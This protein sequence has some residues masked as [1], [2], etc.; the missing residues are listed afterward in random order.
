MITGDRKILYTIFHAWSSITRTKGREYLLC[1]FHRIS[2]CLLLLYV[3]L[4]IN[5]LSAL[6]TPEVY[7]EKVK[8]FSGWFM[9]FLEWLLAIPV[10]FHCLNGARVIVYE[11]F[12]TRWDAQLSRLIY[13]LCG[14]YMVMLGYFMILG[15]QQVT[16]HFY[17]VNI[18]IASAFV[19]YLTITRIRRTSTGIAW[20]MQRISGSF[21]FLIVPAHMIFMHLNPQTGKDAAFITERLNQPFIMLVDILLLLSI[22]YHGGYGVIGICRDYLTSKEVRTS[23]ILGV[24]VILAMFGIQGIKLIISV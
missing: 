24:V 8:L 4:H 1:W 12:D 17:W 11:L 7:A 15:D 2:G 5:T 21:L 3:L 14:G 19:C 13:P 23:C 20:K 6:S 22:L 18:V 9:V 10:I 16:A